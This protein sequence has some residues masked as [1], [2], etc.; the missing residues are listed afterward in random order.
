MQA[1]YNSNNNFLFKNMVNT[2]DFHLTRENNEQPYKGRRVKQIKCVR[3]GNKPF[4]CQA[5]AKILHRHHCDEFERRVT[6][7]LVCPRT[8]RYAWFICRFIAR[9]F[10]STGRS[11]RII[12]FDVMNNPN[13]SIQSEIWMANCVYVYIIYNSNTQYNIR[14]LIHPGSEIKQ[15]VMLM[16]ITHYITTSNQSDLG[17]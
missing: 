7:R 17:L 14:G 4:K 16:M 11:Y 10:D 2:R 13:H 9:A 6:T 3:D 15:H 8:G 5:A 12:R 1:V